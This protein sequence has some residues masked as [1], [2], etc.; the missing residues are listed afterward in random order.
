MQIE[1]LVPVLDSTGGA[2]AR[3]FETEAV[4][5]ATTHILDAHGRWAFVV[6]SGPPGVGK[7]TCA[8]F[9]V[10]LVNEQAALGEGIK[11][12]TWEVSGRN[13]RQRA[14]Q[15]TRGG[16]KELYVQFIGSVPSNLFQRETEH[17]VCRRLIAV[18][19]QRGLQLLLLDEAGTMAPEELRGLAMVLNVAREEEWPLTMVLVG[20]DDIAT[21]MEALPQVESRVADWVWFHPLTVEDWDGVFSVL[22]PSMAGRAQAPIRRWTWKTLKGGARRLE[23]LLS[24]V[25]KSA[26]ALEIAPAALTLDQFQAIYEDLASRR[27]EVKSSG[28]FLD[29]AKGRVRV[30]FEDA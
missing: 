21:T 12:H 3:P 2:T 4:R 5:L 10:S 20:M 11:A 6:M 23:H 18:L 24:H 8:K 25:M 15:S 22:M 16:L 19:R 13:K 17:S 26:A 1:R 14:Q 9:M 28:R 30:D 7:T 27:Q 29:A